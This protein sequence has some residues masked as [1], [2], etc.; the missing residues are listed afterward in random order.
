[1]ACIHIYQRIVLHMLLYCDYF[2]MPPKKDLKKL[3]VPTSF[4]F[5]FFLASKYFVVWFQ[6]HFFFFSI[7][8][9]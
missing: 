8:D 9:L 3:K 7:S 6:N 1:M 4:F 2:S 5:F